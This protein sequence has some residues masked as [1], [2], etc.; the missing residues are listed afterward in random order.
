[1]LLSLLSLYLYHLNLIRLN[2]TTNERMKNVFADGVSPETTL[3]DERSK[4]S[5][6]AIGRNFM[7]ARGN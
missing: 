7:C 4:A 3:L 6:Q 1:M 2:Q 5:K